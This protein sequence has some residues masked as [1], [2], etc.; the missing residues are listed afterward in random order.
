[1]SVVGLQLPQPSAQTGFGEPAWCG[2]CRAQEKNSWP[3]LSSRPKAGGCAPVLAIT[4]WWPHPQTC[5]WTAPH[6]CSLQN[7]GLEAIPV[8][9]WCLTSPLYF[10]EGRHQSLNSEGWVCWHFRGWSSFFPW[11]HLVLLSHI[12]LFR[13]P[14]LPPM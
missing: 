11:G 3:G 13:I 10:S 14:L 7:R 6:H 4:Q 1:V 9:W 12:Q 5:G 8:A 2:L